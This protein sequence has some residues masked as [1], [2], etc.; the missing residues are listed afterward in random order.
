MPQHCTDQEFAEIVSILEKWVKAHPNPES[1]GFKDSEL[2]AYSKTTEWFMD[3]QHQT[4][5]GEL[6]LKHLKELS[7]EE[8]I[9]IVE[10]VRKVFPE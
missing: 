6:L 3:I 8:G 9:S 10:F 1:E 5:F 2:F 7:D 4:P